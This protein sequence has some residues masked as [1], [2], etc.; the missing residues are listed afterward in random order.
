MEPLPAGSSRFTRLTLVALALFVLLAVVAFASR[1]GFG[2]A[3][4]ARPSPS[5]VSW[6]SSIFLVLYVLAIPFAAYA[7]FLQGRE[8]AVRR[9]RGL[10]QLM[11]QNVVTF[12]LFLGMIG[13]FF[14]IRHLRP[15]FLDLQNTPL[16]KA[17]KANRKAGAKGTG[18]EPQFHWAVAVVAAVLVLALAVTG[19]VLYR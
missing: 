11:I 8:G 3:S 10:K 7:F 15:H 18:I 19:F 1:S 6:A 2:G 12:G 16:G 4:D 5:Y 9:S 13:F 14:Y 17:G